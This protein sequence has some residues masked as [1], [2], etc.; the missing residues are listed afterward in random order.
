M[1]F[2]LGDV[3]LPARQIADAVSRMAQDISLDYR[4]DPPVIIPLL[5]GAFIFCADL[6]RQLDFECQIMFV[7]A[8]SYQ[9]TNTSGTVTISGLDQ[10]NLKNRRILV[11][12]DI[13]DTGLTLAKVVEAISQKSPK[14]VRIAT[15]LDKPSRRVSKISPDYTGFSIPDHFVVGYG[16]DFNDRFRNLPDIC[17]MRMK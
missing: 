15:L 1:E 3:L 6:V 9:G 13:I 8:A 17:Q 7:K 10:L 5:T 11:V 12:E 4:K 2:E 16:L 14:D